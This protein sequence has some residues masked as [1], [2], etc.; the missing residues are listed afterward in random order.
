VVALPWSTFRATLPILG[1]P[2]TFNAAVPLTPKQFNYAFTNELDAAAS[3]KVYDELHIPAAARVLWQGALSLLN[4]KGATAV[5]YRNDD[6]APLLFIAGGNDHIVPASVN[7]ANARK[8]RHSKAVT[9]Y[10]EFPGRTHHTVG[11][12]GW[13]EVADYGLKW[14]TGHARA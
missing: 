1:N 8:Y 10:K 14:A 13:E 11:Q 9:D 5:N 6:R 7:R 12:D 4:P 3:K 2:F